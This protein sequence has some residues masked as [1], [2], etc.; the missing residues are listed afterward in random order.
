M[1][2]PVGTTVPVAGVTDAVKVSAVPLVA[3][4]SLE[5]S[6]VAVGAVAGPVLKVNSETKPVVKFVELKTFW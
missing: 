5:V 3:G 2:S 1:T 6:S 4:F